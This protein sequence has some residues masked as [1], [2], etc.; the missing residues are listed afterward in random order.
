MTGA[1]GDESRA[2]NA[3]SGPCVSGAVPSHA[4]D[5]AVAR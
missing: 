2:P 1:K 5:E 4:F 3:A